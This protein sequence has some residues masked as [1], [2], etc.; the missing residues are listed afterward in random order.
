M[1]ENPRLVISALKLAQPS[2]QPRIFRRRS[3]SVRSNISSYSRIERPHGT[4]LSN[5]TLGMLAISFATVARAIDTH[6]TNLVGNLVNH[7]IVAH[8]DAPV[9]FTADQLAATGR[10]GV[11]CQ[12]LH[13][14]HDA[15]V[16]LGRKSGEVF[17]DA[18]FKQDAIHGHL[19]LRSARYSSS[20][21]YWSGLRR[22]RLSQAIS[23]ASSTR[24][25]N[26]S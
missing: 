1:T 6:D 19:R 9:V 15:V 21:R 2:P 5:R 13:R 22:A 4:M 24:S 11:Y 10:A 26:S 14:R 8:A 3:V 16:Y 17:L 12:C 18:A 23:S 7:A 20:R 25:S